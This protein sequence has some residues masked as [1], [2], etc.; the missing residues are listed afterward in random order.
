MMG[1]IEMVINKER[2]EEFDEKEKSW[3]LFD[4]MQD[5][6]KRVKQLENRRT[7]DTIKVF[8]GGVIGGAAAA[9]GMK[10]GGLR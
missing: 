2:W 5:V 1:N 7:W 8:S 4:T 9:L 10:W 6:K 3:I